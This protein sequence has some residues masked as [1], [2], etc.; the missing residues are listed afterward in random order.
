MILS[1]VRCPASN[2]YAKRPHKTQPTQ[3]CPRWSQL[4][5]PASAWP[6]K[7]T[8]LP[9]APWT[10]SSSLIFR[11]AQILRT[12]RSCQ[13]SWRPEKLWF[14][15]SDLIGCYS[16]FLIVIWLAQYWPIDCSTDLIRVGWVIV[17]GMNIRV[18]WHIAVNPHL[19]TIVL[20]VVVQILLMM[21]ITVMLAVGIKILVVSHIGFPSCLRTLQPICYE[22]T[23]DS[24]HEQNAKDPCSC[25]FSLTNCKI[26]HYTLITAAVWICRY[27]AILT[28]VPS[29]G[30]WS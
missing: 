11:L 29:A 14:R 15:K 30:P 27:A 22:H 6:A 13:L 24:Y 18:S 5:N 7:T 19:T 20:L 17:G 2:W 16:S 25:R 10:P 1:N 26:K 3:I 12:W 23:D 8:A 4:A 21:L 28:T 9:T